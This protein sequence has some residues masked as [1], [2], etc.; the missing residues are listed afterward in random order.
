M[1][2]FLDSNKLMILSKVS[3]SSAPRQWWNSIDP[4]GDVRAL[5]GVPVLCPRR[6]RCQVSF[7]LAFALQINDFELV[8]VLTP[9]V[10]HLFPKT[11][12]A[13]NADGS[14][15][16]TRAKTIVAAA[17]MRRTLKEFVP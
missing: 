8:P 12:P 6:T 1:P 4:L 2:G 9:S 16:A 14:V 5:T 10:V 13:A 7:P 17:L 3:P 11:S 15:V